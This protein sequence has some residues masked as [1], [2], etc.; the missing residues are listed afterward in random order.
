MNFIHR[1]RH[2][3]HTT[4]ISF[5]PSLCFVVDMSYCYV[6][7][8]QSGTSPHHTIR[9]GTRE[10]N[11]KKWEN[12]TSCSS[13]SE[14]ESKWLSSS[15]SS[16]FYA[17]R[18]RIFRYFAKRLLKSWNQVFKFCHHSKSDGWR[19]HGIGKLLIGKSV[20]WQRE[21][22][23]SNERATHSTKMYPY[24][25]HRRRCFVESSLSFAVSRFFHH[26]VDESEI[27]NENSVKFSPQLNVSASLILYRWYFLLISHSH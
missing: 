2:E 25:H 23:A 21:F 16:E 26:R 3:Q 1:R 13:E 4:F 20:R 8:Q 9:Q 18:R 11:R 22:R 5:F 12:T 24:W 14:R 17:R 27:E 10:G 6:V 19:S 15:V 7:H